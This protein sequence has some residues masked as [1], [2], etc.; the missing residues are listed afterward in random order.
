M[1]TTLVTSVPK[2]LDLMPRH[3]Q[4]ESVA[5]AVRVRLLTQF[6]TTARKIALLLLSGALAVR[7][8]H[9][10]PHRVI[11][12]RRGLLAQFWPTASLLRRTAQF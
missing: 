4:K 8:R 9:L 7:M 11:A 5:L 10:M 3:L 1:A 6:W 2:E 12:R